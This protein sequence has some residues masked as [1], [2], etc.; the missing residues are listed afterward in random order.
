MQT[1][2]KTI[3][4]CLCGKNRMNGRRKCLGCIRLDGRKKRLEK[5]QQKLE[6]RVKL[7]E[8]KA[9]SPK[10]LKKKLDQVFS[11]YIRRRAADSNGMIR[12]VCCGKTLPWKE[13]QNMHYVGRANMNTRWDEKNC[14]PGCLRCNVMMNGNYP[15]YTKY[16]LDSYGAE[17]LQEL[18]KRGQE[19]RKWSVEELKRM[20]VK[21]S[22]LIKSL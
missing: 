18:I 20:V 22:E 13:A 6:R 4:K 14:Y 15:A 1:L 5:L 9:S 2:T 8:R 11:E 16:L 10:V 19:I 12:C 17:W 21:Y 3:A 7:K